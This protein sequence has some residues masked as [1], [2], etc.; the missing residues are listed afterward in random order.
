M[1]QSA[2]TVTT[3]MRGPPPLVVVV[4]VVLLLLRTDGFRRVGDVGNRAA[5]RAFYADH[6]LVHAAAAAAGD[7]S[8]ATTAASNFLSKKAFEDIGVSATLLPVTKALNLERPS[9]I[10]ALSYRTVAEG[11]TSIIADQTGSGKTLA[12]LLPTLQRMY[13]LRRAGT[14]G[15]EVPSRSP[16]ILI[17]APTTE[18]AAQAS[19]VVKSVSNVLKYRTA[20]L[21]SIGDADV[22]QKKLR[23]GAEVVV[24]TPGRLAAA[25]AKG[26]IFL[27]HVQ[28]AVLDEADVLFMD[29]SFPLEPIGASCPAD[30][31]FVF[32]TATLP[33]VV[34]EQIV[35]EFPNVQLLK[36]P[37]LHR[38]SPMVE[39]VLIDCSGAST[40]EKTPETAF[41][42]KRLALLR[43]LEQTTTER[44]VVFCNTIAQ[45][46]KVE[47][48]LQR[49]DR[50]GR[51]RTVLPYHGAVDTDARA[52]A[53]R[54]FCRPLLK[55]PTV[56]VCTDRASRGI[57]F[58]RAQ[59]RGCGDFKCFSLTL[60]R[61]PHRRKKQRRWT[62]SSCL[63]FLRSPAS[64]FDAS[65]ELD[66]RVAKARSP[67]LSTAGKCQ[68]QNRSSAP[69]SRAK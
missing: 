21:S 47:N 64:T 28:S 11:K 33:A 41:E 49:A 19:R 12:Y 23:L 4:V 1:D 8:H 57:D 31:Q 20:C 25:M 46:R 29:Q 42:N 37:G 9:K 22:E 65:A 14:L 60:S 7:G 16:Y 62:T 51:L 66:A 61:D 5:L 52:D 35:A 15:N 34:T 30:T 43:S 63:T 69:A 39:E 26:E 13:D 18:L 58:D 55:V 56:L 50:Q 67:S 36:G 48:A 3:I 38:I 6:V 45:C 32:V 68:S 44:T 59:V 24:A 10:Q 54:E 40:Q 2:S 53:M 27:T 17:V